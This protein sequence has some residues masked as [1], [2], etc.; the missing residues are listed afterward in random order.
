[1]KAYTDVNEILDAVKDHYSLSSDGQIA[2]KLGVSRY[3]ISNWRCG[4]NTIDDDIAIVIE[5]VLKLPEGVISLEMHSQRTKCPA[6]SKTFHQ[7]AQKLAA[8]ALCIML[9]FGTLL[10]KPATASSQSVS[11]SELNNVY[12]MRIYNR[13]R[14]RRRRV[15]N[16]LIQSSYR[17]IGKILLK[18]RFYKIDYRDVFTGRFNNNKGSFSHELF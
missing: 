2:K 16:C 3:R 13:V 4:K 11:M 18:L 10:P 9:V 17:F 1:M 15:T 7:L 6:V 8:G 12:I 5:N 14:R